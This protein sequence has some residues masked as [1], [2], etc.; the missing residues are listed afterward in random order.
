MIIAIIF[1]IIFLHY[2]LL[3]LPNHQTDSADSS[4]IFR[5]FC[6]CAKQRGIYFGCVCLSVCLYVCLSD[7]NFWKP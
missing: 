7:D 2:L 4:T 1:T 6:P 5:I 3:S